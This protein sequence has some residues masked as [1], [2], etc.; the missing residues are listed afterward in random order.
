MCDGGGESPK[1]PG[2]KRVESRKNIT[3][4]FGREGGSLDI[5]IQLGATV[6]TCL[7]AAA[8]IFVSSPSHCIFGRAVV[9]FV[10]AC[11]SKLL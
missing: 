11:I 6:Q 10:H 9:D 7:A 3:V 4:S 2:K 8:E 1:N 5:I